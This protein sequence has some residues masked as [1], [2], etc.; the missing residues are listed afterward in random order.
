MPNH[1]YTTNFDFEVQA[2]DS[3]SNIVLSKANIQNLSSL[4]PTQVDLEKNIDLMGVAFNAAVV[5]EFNK[6]GDGISTETAIDSVQQFVHKPTNIEHD[7][8]KV[9]GHIVNAGFSDYTDS[10][11]L[12]NVDKE[13]KDPFNIA[14]GAVV[15]KT[16]DKEFFE[17]LR[18]STDPKNKLHNTVSASWEVGFSDYKIA[19]GSKNLKDAEIISDPKQIMEMKAMLRGFGG[20][21]TMKDG[22]PLYRLIVGNVYPLGIGFTM[23]PAANVKGVISE[24]SLTP[25]VKETKAIEINSEHSKDLQKIAAKISQRIKNTVNNINIM[26]IENLLTELKSD[27]QEKKFSQEAIAS[28]TSTFAEAIKTKDEEYKASLEA[29]ENEKA[30]IAKANEE[31]KTSV[32]SIKEELASAQERIAE[33]E[34]A[35]AAEE[36]VATFN[37][38]MEEIDSIYDLEESDSSFI[39]EKIKGLDSSEESFASLK[40][41]LEVF[42]ASKNK[43]AKAKFEEEVQARV[44][45]EVEKRLQ[46]TEVS[47]ASE[48][49]EETDVAEALENAEATTSEIPNNN[50]AQAS[51]KSFKDRFASAFSRDNVLS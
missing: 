33:F 14:L 20:K 51:S 19:V 49:S 1:R 9:V 2:S 45:E 21:G 13:T 47:E 46:T 24:E 15:Y 7:K 35:K 3:I 30:E 22:T 6:N 31:L 38:R 36:A 50:E 28:M 32:E 12:V 26:D 39:A 10:T 42:W 29:A 23:K 17:T 18:R 27:L 43:E 48:S 37:A 11:I 41:E 25:E 8:K 5:N 40:S 4:I 16:V 34:K 44:N